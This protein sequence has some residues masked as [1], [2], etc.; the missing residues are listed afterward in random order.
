MDPIQR[1][2]IFKTGPANAN[3]SRRFG[4]FVR[5]PHISRLRLILL[6]AR[7]SHG[8]I[9][10]HPLLSIWLQ[11]AEL[12]FSQMIQMIQMFVWFTGSSSAHLVPSQPPPPAKQRR[13][14]VV[15]TFLDIPDIP[16]SENSK[17]A[18][19]EQAKKK[20]KHA[21]L[22]DLCFDGFSQV[23]TTASLLV[24]CHF[25]HCEAKHLSGYS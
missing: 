18:K 22:T 8:S 12:Q 13:Q 21:N 4:Q 6:K 9:I 17:Q 1:T 5:Q 14:H 24:S 10:F 7:S 23:S 20:K 2:A 3:I 16:A 15:T 19:C 11:P 25:V